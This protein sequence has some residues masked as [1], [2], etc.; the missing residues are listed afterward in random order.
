MRRLYLALPGPPAVR[1]VLVAGLALVVLVLLLSAFEWVGDR[2]L[3]T[4]GTIEG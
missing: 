3:D 2:L 4:G 1:A